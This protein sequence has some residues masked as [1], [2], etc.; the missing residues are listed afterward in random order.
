MTMLQVQVGSSWYYRSFLADQ[1]ERLCV[2]YQKAMEVKR[3]LQ[4]YNYKLY[5]Q[6]SF[7]V[8]FGC[9]A[10]ANYDYSELVYFP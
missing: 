2:F 6:V 9:M 7:V 4:K 3:L 8:T 1:K 10:C 5:K